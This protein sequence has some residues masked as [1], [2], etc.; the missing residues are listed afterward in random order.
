MYRFIA[1]QPATTLAIVAEAPVVLD[2]I[3]S[4][5]GLDNAQGTFTTNLPLAGATLEVFA[6]NPTPA[7]ASA[8]RR[9]RKTIG[10]DGRWG[11]FIADATARY[12]FVVAATGYATTHIYRSPFP[13]SSDIVNMH[14]ER[15]A[16]ADRDARRWC[17]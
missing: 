16:D 17:S 7:S 15:L 2:G 4:G 12:E 14:P 5:L 8:R 1:G 13:R 6:T 9:H 11:P 3:V 10:G